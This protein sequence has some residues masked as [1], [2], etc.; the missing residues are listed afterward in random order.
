MKKD[1]DFP[2]VTNVGV[3]IVQ[4]KNEEEAMVWN[5]YLLNLKESLI[6]DV[7]VSTR[8]YGL[9]N[10]ETRKTSELRHFL[11]T[12]EPRS[13]VKIEPIMEEVF[14]L[15]NEYWVSF[16]HEG[17]MYDKKFIFLT[18]TIKPENCVKVPLINKKG[19]LIL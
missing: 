8:G 17:V 3:A 18:E 14:L 13:F 1:I 9:I 19:V 4:E 6:A 2:T 11:D 7:L 10:E 5:V 12:V 15:N 16:F